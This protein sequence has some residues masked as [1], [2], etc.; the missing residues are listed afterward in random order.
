MIAVSEGTP[1]EAAIREVV[2]WL[3]THSGRMRVSVR[4]FCPT[5]DVLM[6]AGKTPSGLTHY[7]CPCEGCRETWKGR[8][9]VV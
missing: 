9:R 1:K 5:H 6:L 4:P 8:H 7:Y 2:N 3:K